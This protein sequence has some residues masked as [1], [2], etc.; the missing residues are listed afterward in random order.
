M[1]VLYNILLVLTLP[2]WAVWMAV[3]ARRRKEP[4]DWNE[5]QGAYPFV[6][7]RSQRR[8]WVHAVSVGEFMACQ[9]LLRALRALDPTPEVVVSTTTSSGHGAAEKHMGEMFDRLVYFPIDVPRFCLKALLA[10][11]PTVIVVMETEI[12]PN[13]L[14]T[15]R[16]MGIPTLVA[17]GRISDRTFSRRWLAGLVYRPV[18][19]YLD[20]VLAQSETDRERF[21]A[22]GARQVEVLGNTKFDQALSGLDADPNEWR[23]TLGIPSGAPVIVV[24]S[25]RS[26]LEETLVANAL[27]DPSLHG[28]ALVW[29]PRHIERAQEV[30]AQLRRIG[31]DPELRSK[32]GQGDTVVLDTYGELAMVYS[33]ADVVI[34]GGGFDE[35][36]GQDILQ[37]MAHG[38]PVIH[39]PNMANFRDVARLAS[40]AGAT[41]V[42]EPDPSVLAD[43][44]TKLLDDPA[45]RKRAG[46][47]GRS[48][49]Q[50]HQGA[51]RRIADRVE[52]YFDAP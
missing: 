25:T 44:V 34:V 11:K 45:L 20:A 42:C 17:N 48:L 52:R 15:A 36:G 6:L 26:D 23:G 5:R 9:P 32:G 28:A 29:A 51:G 37:P 2:I 27:S 22:L 50:S 38:K 49:I 19:R 7:G 30:A 40:E 24:G 31:R 12:W 10:V 3:R 47:A 18:L 16:E 43:T 21:L 14:W 33:V 13:F 39:G 1:I 4:V 46:E 41:L 8:V 35:L